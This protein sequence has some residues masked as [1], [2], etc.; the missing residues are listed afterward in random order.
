MTGMTEP[1][2]GFKSG[3]DIRVAMRSLTEQL[4]VDTF[5]EKEKYLRQIINIDK[6]FSL[7]GSLLVQPFR[8]KK[9]LRGINVKLV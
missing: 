8:E 4:S 7:F 6:K 5:I 2:P 1:S 9:S 3:I